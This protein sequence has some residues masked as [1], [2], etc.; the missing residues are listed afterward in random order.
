MLISWQDEDNETG[1]AV[2]KL[3][4][5]SHYPSVTSTYLDA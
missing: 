3:L 5:L 4:A 2:E 1:A